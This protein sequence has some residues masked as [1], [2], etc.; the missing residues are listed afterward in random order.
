MREED[1]IVNFIRK[2]NRPVSTDA[3][4]ILTGMDQRD[5]REKLGSLQKWKK[6]KKV[7]TSRVDFWN[8]IDE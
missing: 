7:C 8:F 4:T 2:A 1:R 3:I 5:V 6:V